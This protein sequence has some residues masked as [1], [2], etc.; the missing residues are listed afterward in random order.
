MSCLLCSELVQ[1]NYRFLDI[2]LL[3]RI[4]S[5]ICSGCQSSFSRISLDHCKQC[6]K[7][8][9]SGICQDCLYWRN[10][11]Q[12]VSHQALYVYNQAMK[13]YFSRYKFQ[14]DYC[15]RLV[16]AKDIRVALLPY[17]D[18]SLVPIPL[19]Q[20]GL[21]ER[22]FNQV[23]AFLDEAKLPYHN[24]L[25]KRASEKQSSKDRQSR[26]ATQQ[27]FTLKARAKLPQKICLVDDIYTT[28]TTIQ[29]AKQLLYENGVKTIVSFSLA[30]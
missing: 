3:K 17:R 18:Y 22:G 8:A 10:K 29:L 16:F 28:G 2:I 9:V 23:Q 25:E 19:S 5:L 14:G 7:E 1:K 15:L 27:P 11:G 13:D 21:K 30:R 4:D 20:I 24:L 6:F 26:L 12:T